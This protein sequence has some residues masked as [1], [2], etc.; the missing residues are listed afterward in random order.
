MAFQREVSDRGHDE[1]ILRHLL[2]RLLPPPLCGG[3]VDVVVD[4]STSPDS[5]YNS[6]PEQSEGG[7][8]VVYRDEAVERT[9]VGAARERGR[10]DR[11][12]D[13]ERSR[14]RNRDRDKD[15]DRSR[16]RNRDRDRDRDRSRDRNRDRDRDRDKS[17]RDRDRDNDRNRGRNRDYSKNRA[18]RDRPSQLERRDTFTVE[19]NRRHGGGDVDPSFGETQD[20]GGMRGVIERADRRFALPPEVRNYLT[21]HFRMVREEN[22]KLLE[23]L[24]EAEGELRR[25]RDQHRWVRCVQALIDS[26]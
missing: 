7:S 10:D 2:L 15:R 12:R 3:G 13:G 6:S 19:D 1:K 16:D 26:E 22:E 17:S 23:D 5:D 25:F 4:M 8:L 21:S 14:D 18:D 24:R 9:T 20:A 11:N